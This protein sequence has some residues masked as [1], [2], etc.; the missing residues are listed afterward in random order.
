ML[1]LVDPLFVAMEIMLFTSKPILMIMFEEESATVWIL[2]AKSM[3]WLLSL[4][5]MPSFHS[6]ETKT[7]SSVITSGTR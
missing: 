7:I 4:A 5:A 2:V 1:E 6:L 3:T